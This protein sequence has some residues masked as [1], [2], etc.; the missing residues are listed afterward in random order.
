MLHTLRVAAGPT[1]RFC[2]PFSLQ[3]HAAAD[4]AAAT[5]ASPTWRG[6]WHGNTYANAV[7]AMSS[8]QVRG[9]FGRYLLHRL[10]ERGSTPAAWIPNFD[11]SF[12]GANRAMVTRHSLMSDP[13]CSRPEHGAIDGYA[14]AYRYSHLQIDFASG[15]GAGHRSSL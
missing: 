9:N 7:R 8:K 6:I 12:V 4:P 1:G 2:A 3:R 11:G 13:T 5:E 15:A 14:C 10:Q